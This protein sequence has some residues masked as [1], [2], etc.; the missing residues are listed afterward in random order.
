[1]KRVIVDHYGGAEVVK[2]VEDDVR[3]P[4]QG[5]VCVRVLAAQ[6]GSGR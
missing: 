5:E 4:G 6:T 1:M 2:V 3:K